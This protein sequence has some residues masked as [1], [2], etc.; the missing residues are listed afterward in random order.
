VKNATSGAYVSFDEIDQA[1]GPGITPNNDGSV[2]DGG[3]A[4]LVAITQLVKSRD[5]AIIR[6]EKAEADAAAMREALEFADR[7]RHGHVHGGRRGPCG[8]C[9]AIKKVTAALATDAGTALLDER[10]ALR[11]ALEKAESDAAALRLALE[12]AFMAHRIDNCRDRECTCCLWDLGR[13]ALGIAD[14]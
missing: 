8:D 4:R 14:E 3:H 12:D 13:A 7:W 1:M 10:D 11:A 2:D 5:D 6:A 9:A